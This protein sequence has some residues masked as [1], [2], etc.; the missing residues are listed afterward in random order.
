MVTWGEILRDYIAQQVASN[1]GDYSGI[2]VTAMED[3][4][5]LFISVTNE[6]DIE[7]NLV[8]E[9]DEADCEKVFKNF[10]YTGK[11]VEGVSSFIAADY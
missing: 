6:E 8:Y 11:Y 5:M 3:G 10:Y 9:L 2:H 7:P 4:S 1:K